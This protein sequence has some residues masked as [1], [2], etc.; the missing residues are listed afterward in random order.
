[1]VLGDLVWRL[2]MPRP[3]AAAG[4]IMISLALAG[5]HL[6]TRPIVW[7][8]SAAPAFVC[9]G[10]PAVVSWEANEMIGGCLGDG[11]PEPFSVEISSMPDVLSGSW[12][13]ARGSQT[14]APISSRTSFTITPHGG[15]LPRTADSYDVDVVLPERETM[16]PV[17]LEGFCAGSGPAWQPLTLSA[18]QFRSESVRVVRACNFSRWPV[19]V[20]IQSDLGTLRQTLVPG[21]CMPDLPA[22]AGRTA[23]SMTVSSTDPSVVGGVDCD[24]RGSYPPALTI[25]LALACDMMSASEP[26][27]AATPGTDEPPTL[28][29]LLTDTPEPTPTPAGPPLAT[30]TQNANCRSGPGT[31]YDLLRVFFQGES[32]Q[33]EGRSAG[34]PR[35]WWLR[36][37]G[38]SR[39]CWA[40]EVT[41]QLDRAGDGVPVIE[42]PPTPTSAPAGPPAAPGQLGIAGVVCTDQDYV[43]TLSWIDA[44]SNEQGY[45]VY[46]DGG[47]IATLGPNAAGYSDEPPGSGP[48]TYGVEAFNAAGASSRPTVVEPGCL[49]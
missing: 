24:V 36:M 17:T 43:V 35:W 8:T 48:Y 4:L 6:D 28:V 45:R 40:S 47:L 42:A 18:P 49:Y 29:A 27:T 9:P 11:C 20:S 10:E 14:S 44:A 30:F 12:R 16:M 13:L 1:M 22:D 39:H 2:R 34:A 38:S 32:A 21:M 25:G 26:I 41:V 19:T 46:R 15:E 7:V 3:A 33:V 5:C 23:Q 37:P 31:I